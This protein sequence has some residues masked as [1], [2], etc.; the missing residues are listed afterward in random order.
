MGLVLAD[1]PAVDIQGAIEQIMIDMYVFI[2]VALADGPTHALV[3]C[4]RFPRNL[5]EMDCDRVFLKVQPSPAILP[6]M[7][8]RVLPQLKSS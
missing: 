7:T 6:P 4:L 8:M 3:H 1:R 2:E 5:V